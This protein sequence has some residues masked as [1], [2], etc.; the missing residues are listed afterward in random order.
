MAAVLKN[1]GPRE[2]PADNEVSQ[3]VARVVEKVV[4]AAAVATKADLRD[5]KW[6]THVIKSGAKNAFVLPTGDIFVYT[7]MLELCD[8]SDQLAFVVAHEVVSARRA[9]L[10]PRQRVAGACCG[11]YQR[12]QEHVPS[13]THAGAHT[14]CS[15][16]CH[17]LHLSPCSWQAHVL[18]RHAAEKIGFAVIAMFIVDMLRPYRS[19]MSGDLVAE[20]AG[21]IA[22]AM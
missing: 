9:S 19:F 17:P 22:S 13:H 15:P 1:E 7:G 8:N 6:R 10:V 3:H 4:A 11:V 16:Q 12:K 21:V 2:L 20:L 14:A 18:G 5:V